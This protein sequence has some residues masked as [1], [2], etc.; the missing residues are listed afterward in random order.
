MSKHTKLLYA[1]DMKY[2]PILWLVSQRII[3]GC[4]SWSGIYLYTMEISTQKMYI[5]ITRMWLH[6]N[7]NKYVDNQT[8]EVIMDTK[9]IIFNPIPVQYKDYILAVAGIIS[10]P[11]T[12]SHSSVNYIK[13][14]KIRS[15]CDMYWKLHSGIGWCLSSF[16]CDY[17]LK[18]H[19][20]GAI[21]L[22]TNSDTNT[23]TYIWWLYGMKT[24]SAF[25]VICMGNH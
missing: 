7:Y 25:P 17:W 15:S 4:Y 3:T 1:S 5:R 8:L 19:T 22:N 23:N 2:Q 9:I 20:S 11:T 13:V 18:F 10:F 16:L 6:Q 14:F 24:L 21:F 12:L